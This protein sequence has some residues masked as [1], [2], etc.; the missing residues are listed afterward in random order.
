MKKQVLGTK[1][2][3]IHFMLVLLLCEEKVDN[4]LLF[5][6]SLLQHKYVTNLLL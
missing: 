2:I 4:K 3:R 6:L 1:K 5:F